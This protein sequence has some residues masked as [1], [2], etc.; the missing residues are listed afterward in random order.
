LEEEFTG[1]SSYFPIG[2][3]AQSQLLHS[4]L[5]AVFGLAKTASVQQECAAKGD[6]A[7]K[8]RAAA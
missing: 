5:A 4:P 2:K 8:S 7:W 3:T 1:K 6:L